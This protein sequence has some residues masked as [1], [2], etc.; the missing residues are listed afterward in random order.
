MSSLLRLWDLNGKEAAVPLGFVV[1]VL[2]ICVISAGRALL[3]LPEILFR[4]IQGQ[5][6]HFN[7]GKE[8]L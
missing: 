6:F 3:S 7:G 8:D 2:A 5:S 1:P 4:Y